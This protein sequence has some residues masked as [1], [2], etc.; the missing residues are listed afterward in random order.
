MRRWNKVLTAALLAAAFAWAVT[1]NGSLQV[2][3][4]LSATVV[5]FTS[6]TS[7]APMRA[8]TGLPSACSVGQAFFKTDATAG[9]N[10]YLCTAANTW[11]QVQGGGGSGVFDWKPSTRYSVY[12]T[13]FPYVWSQGSPAYFGDWIFQR[14]AGSQNLNNPR[15]TLPN[16]SVVGVIGVSTTTTSGNRT[17]WAAETGGFSADAVSLYTRTNLDWEFLVIFRWPE[18]ADYTNST[19]FLGMCPNATDNP[20]IGVG[21]RYLAGTDATLRFFANS[22]GG[23]WGSLSDSGVAPDTAWH[24]LRIRSDGTQTSR[25]WISLDGGTERSICPSGCDLTLG[26]TNSRVWSGGFGISL[27]TNEA[28]QKRVQLDYLHLWVDYGTAR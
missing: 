10:I 28:A 11:T 15:G 5:D 3:G 6:S 24:K 13:D 22:T 20:T 9:Q 26:T 7:T 27:A 2:L 1:V 18:A 23:V 12:K 17:Y 19:T 25:A 16:D 8:G 14:I 21:V 4:T